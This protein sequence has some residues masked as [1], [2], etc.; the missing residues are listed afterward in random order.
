MSMDIKRIGQAA[1]LLVCLS[2]L[3]AYADSEYADS[4]QGP[5]TQNQLPPSVVKKISLAPLPVQIYFQPHDR[6]T[7]AFTTPCIEIE[8]ASHGF[9]P[10]MAFETF[11]FEMIG[12][13]NDSNVLP[14]R[15]EPVCI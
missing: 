6:P 8:K 10:F 15:L 1:I 3:S 11:M 4:Q 2:G 14:A 5:A 7:I 13:V 9:P 12:K